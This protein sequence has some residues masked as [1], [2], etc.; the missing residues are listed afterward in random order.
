MCICLS[1]RL[2]FITD[3]WSRRDSRR[4]RHFADCSRS[5]PKCEPPAE[6][7][8]SLP[9]NAVL[10]KLFVHDRLDDDMHLPQ[11]LPVTIPRH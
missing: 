11:M 7:H 4:H 6:A 9:L 1:I 5:W 2:S 10:H 8:T 3:V